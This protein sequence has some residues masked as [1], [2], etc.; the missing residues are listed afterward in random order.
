M[1]HG[2]VDDARREDPMTGDTEPHID[3]RNGLVKL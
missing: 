3:L 1:S 2:A